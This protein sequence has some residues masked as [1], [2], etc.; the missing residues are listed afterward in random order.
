M[1]KKQKAT[2][3]ERREYI[4]K[5]IEKY[6]LWNIPYSGIAKQFDC[7]RSMIYKDVQYI[8]EHTDYKKDLPR[9]TL[10]LYESYKTAVREMLKILSSNK[11]DMREKSQAANSLAR[12]NDS[13]VNSLEKFGI[14]D[15]V[16]PIQDTTITVLWGEKEDD[17]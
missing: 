17:T 7:H 16:N 13:M 1:F 12:L 8:I 10:A 2:Y 14:K 15:I 4:K 3:T 5:Y 11:A 6:G 9:T